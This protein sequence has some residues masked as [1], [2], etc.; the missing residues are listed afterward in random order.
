MSPD[1]AY[2]VRRTM[3]R[4]TTVALGLLASGLATMIALSP[5]PARSQSAEDKSAA[6]ALFDE[7]KRLL[8]DNRIAEACTRF[9][10]SQRLDP[11]VGTLL[12]L[13]DCYQNVGRIASAWATFR[14]AASAAKATG[15]T[16][17]ETTARQR[18]TQ[19]D[20]KLYMFTLAVGGAATPGLRVLRNDIEV[21]KEAWE[22]A[23]PVDPGIYKVAVTA[24]GKKPWSTTVEV[25]KGAGA[26]TVTVPVLEDLPPQAA[27]STTT[28]VA[29]PPPSGGWSAGR[30][31]G[32][33]VGGLGLVGL[34]IGAGFGL[35]AGSSFSRAKALCPNPTCGDSSGVALAHTAGSQADVA[36]A[37]FAVGGA[38]LAGG[39]LLMV[40]S[41]SPSP[42]SGEANK[43]WI[44][45]IVGSG[46]AGIHAG[47]TW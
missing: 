32:A 7:G 15:Q 36:T 2:A 29:P 34:G 3:A 11:G 19:L 5:R 14:E 10:S 45:P 38:A 13:A 16:D 31:A 21:K 44:S 9:E 24:P 12:F 17:R 35:S 6:E 39:I 26:Q 37:L 42:K 18:A 28:P 41:P 40:L 8:A 20:D 4:R 46:V 25:P 23:V 22:A 1:R 43:A 33:V 27:A 30:T 47:R